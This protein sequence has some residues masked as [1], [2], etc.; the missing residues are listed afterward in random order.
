MFDRH[1]VIHLSL[2]NDARGRALRDGLK[3][4]FRERREDPE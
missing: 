4:Y 3:A 1:G 2:M